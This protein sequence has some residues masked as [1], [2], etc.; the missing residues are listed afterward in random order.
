[1]S[2]DYGDYSMDVGPR[3][4]KSFRPQVK[5][6][7]DPTLPPDLLDVP[8]PSDKST[9]VKPN[10]NPLTTVK[11][12]NPDE[13]P[14]DDPVEPNNLGP[15]EETKRPTF[16]PWKLPPKPV[17]LLPFHPR[18]LYPVIHGQ[19]VAKFS[20]DQRYRDNVP[21][22]KFDLAR[23]KLRDQVLMAQPPPKFGFEGSD[24]Y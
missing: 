4:F 21:R 12:N 8:L 9:T 24:Y 14:V 20:E 13:L 17:E 19:P 22:E 23:E 15:K 10:L 3:R 1:M 11:P 2:F 5:K 16:K 18:P 6:E 7:S